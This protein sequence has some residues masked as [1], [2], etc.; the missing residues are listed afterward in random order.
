MS[1]VVV[2]GAQW[3][4][5]GKGK[6]VD[7]IAN[8][9]DLT[10]R[11]NGGNNA[12][13][14]VINEFGTFPL[15]L[16]PCGVFS[17]KAKSYIS[18]GVVIDPKILVD[19]IKLLQKA[20][21]KLADC[22]FIS[23]RAHV[24]LPY[25]K[26]LDR[27]FE[28]AKAG[29]KTGTTGRG[30]GPVYADKVSYNG[31]RISD[32]IDKKKF[33]KKLEVQ[34]SI[35]N[36]ILKAFGEK[37]LIFEQIEKEY[38]PLRKIIKPFVKE[39]FGEIHAGLKTNKK[40]LLEGAQAVFL[41]TDWGTYPFATAS[42]MLPGAINAS[43]GIPPQKITTTIG[44]VKAYVTRV[45]AGPF[46]TELLDAT[47]EKLRS[48]GH[49]FGTTTGRPR[50]CG[51][52]DAE[53]V[54]FAAELSGI[55]EI[56]LTK[57]DVLDTFSEIQI[58]TGYSLNNKKVRYYDG[59]EAFLGKIKPIYKT[60]KGWNE[61]T[62]GIKKFEKLPVNAKKYILEIEKFAGF[63]IKYISTGPEREALIIK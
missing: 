24:I 63:K 23:P 2:I 29:G 1:V 17:K 41:D 8:T 50:R 56:A 20:K 3:G 60:I 55:S 57:L 48:I 12:G 11:Y 44:V 19:E 26:H 28:A 4:D 52:F 35:K 27:L 53:L 14:T 54:K 37:P 31:I 36:K 62:Q 46:P 16:I 38:A 18:N 45:G 13:H 34:L 21:V 6:I 61:S 40:I 47:G 15:H 33:E 51:W 22:L 42:S 7:A 39:L 5:E 59:D 49:E 10:I 43:A 30:I 58:C 32:F 9:V 25:H